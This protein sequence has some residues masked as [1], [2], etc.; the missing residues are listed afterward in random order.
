[1]N[2]EKYLEPLSAVLELGWAAA[3]CQA[4]GTESFGTDDGLVY[5][6]DNWN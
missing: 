3:I 4:S 6:S 1:M 2:K 5:P